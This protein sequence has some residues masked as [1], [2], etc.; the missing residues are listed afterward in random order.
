MY[1]LGIKSYTPLVDTEKMMNIDVAFHFDSER[2]VFICPNKCEL[3][4]S[5]VHRNHRKKV[6]RASQKDSNRCPVI[7]LKK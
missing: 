2:N 4:Y 6:Y 3:R 7:L 5:S 1:D